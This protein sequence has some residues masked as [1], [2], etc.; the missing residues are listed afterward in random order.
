[1]KRQLHK[2]TTWDRSTELRAQV[3]NK[4]L[5]NNKIACLAR[6]LKIGRFM[7]A[8]KRLLQKSVK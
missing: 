5:K 3:N 8:T 4:R 1:V 7:S 2:R 6:S